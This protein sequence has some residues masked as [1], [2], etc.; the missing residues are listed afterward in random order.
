ML[1]IGVHEVRENF[2]DTNGKA[3]T[4]FRIYDTT[5]SSAPESL[6]AYQDDGGAIFEGRVEFNF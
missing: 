3:D 2:I 6:Y 4:V 1:K 5:S